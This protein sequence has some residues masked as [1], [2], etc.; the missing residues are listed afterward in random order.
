MKEEN[1][2]TAGNPLTCG[3]VGTFGISEDNITG[4]RRRKKNPQNTH[5]T[6][7][8]N[9]EVTQTL[10]STTSEQELGREAQASSSVIRV[11]TR[12]GCPGDNLKG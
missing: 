12:P 2:Q 6:T 4:R 10:T 7:M 1:F 9:G 5:L 8:G 3:S 11:K